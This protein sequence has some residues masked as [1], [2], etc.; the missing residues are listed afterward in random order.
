MEFLRTTIDT[1]D[2]RMR[3]ASLCEIL[4]LA[5]V[6]SIVPRLPV[7]DLQFPCSLNGHLPFHYFT[8]PKRVYKALGCRNLHDNFWGDISKAN[9]H[10]L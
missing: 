8:F 5:S 9:I 1:S 10:N 2:L 3:H 6:L 7:P 4:P